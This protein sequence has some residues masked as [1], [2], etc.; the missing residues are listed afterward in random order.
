MKRAIVCGAGGFVAHHLVRQ[1]KEF[2]Y[3]VRGVDIK[4]PEF[5]DSAADEFLMLDLRKPEDCE[6][7]LGG[8]H[9]DEA[10]QLAADM[11]GM[12]FIHDAECDIMTNSALINNHM[13]NAASAPMDP[14][15]TRRSVDIET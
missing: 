10:Y 8:G 1:L 6:T 14:T 13:I 3:W 15:A 11:G 4:R 9:V 12:G 5:S 2:D 7:A